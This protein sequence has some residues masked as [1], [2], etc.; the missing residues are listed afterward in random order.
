LTALDVPP[1]EL[2]LAVI[3]ALVETHW[4]AD[5]LPL[6]F[7]VST[8]DPLVFA[9]VPVILAAVALAASWLPAR[10]ATRVDPLI[11]IRAE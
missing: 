2:L 8:T 5:G 9:G 10:H 3:V 1:A 11:T 6:L 4:L 7:E